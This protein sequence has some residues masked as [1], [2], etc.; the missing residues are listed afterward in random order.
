M[1]DY[2]VNSGDLRK[3]ITFQQ[4][5]ITQDDGGAQVATWADV[6]SNPT[7]YARWVNAHGQEAIGSDALRSVQ[8]ALVTIRHRT[9]ILVT[10]R[11]LLDSLPWQII[12]I[13][14]V[15]GKNRWIEI[16][17]ERAKGTV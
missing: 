14:P 13:D 10:W 2:R 15:Q 5:T 11:V 4:P 16:V 12:S 3:R 1:A 8:R 17:V 9:D 6:P 7:V